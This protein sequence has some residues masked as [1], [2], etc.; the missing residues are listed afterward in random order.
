MKRALFFLILMIITIGCKTNKPPLYSE[1]VSQ[2]VYATKDSIDA[3]R[4][5][6]ARGYSDQSTRLITPPK[7]R[8]TIPAIYKPSADGK[9]K[10]R[11][12][13]VP[14]DLGNQEVIVVGSEQYEN[15]KKFQDIAIKL[16]EDYEKLKKAKEGVDEDLRKERERVTSIEKE[17]KK[18]QDLVK[19]QNGAIWKRNCIILGLVG[20][21]TAYFYL[22]L[23]GI[24]SFFV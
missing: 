12:I 8:I 11:V 6:L 21:I 23:K 10:Q 19:D 3:S 2:M 17:L 4:I 15:L 20:L 16:E 18:V 13:I 7:E 5:D 14:Q 1:R 24:V 22:K 9:S